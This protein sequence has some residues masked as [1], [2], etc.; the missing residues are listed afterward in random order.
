MKSIRGARS[1]IDDDRKLLAAQ[2]NNGPARRY[3]QVAQ[4]HYPRKK[5]KYDFLC[6]VDSLPI[7]SSG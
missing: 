2:R 3:C 4:P 1:F 5:I 7:L 6:K